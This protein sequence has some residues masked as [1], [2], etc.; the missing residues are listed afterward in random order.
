MVRPANVVE[1]GSEHGSAFVVD[2][3]SVLTHFDNV[4]SLSEILNT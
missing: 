1:R 2:V 4:L 3:S